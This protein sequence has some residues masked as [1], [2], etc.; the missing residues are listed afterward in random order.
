MNPSELS[1]STPSGSGSK[2]S[3]MND[4]PIGQTVVEE[5][6]QRRT[7]IERTKKI[8]KLKLGTDA[9]NRMEQKDEES[10]DGSTSTAISYDRSSFKSE[11]KNFAPKHFGL[12]PE[13]NSNFQNSN[14]K[15]SNFW[16]L[17]KQS[18]DKNYYFMLYFH[19]KKTKTRLVLPLP[20][21]LGLRIRNGRTMIRK[22]L[23]LNQGRPKNL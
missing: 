7:V 12:Y 13:N 6:G 23:T 22:T 20:M 17:C 10:S 16:I 11:S 14:E 9:T 4:V 8:I 3:A 21:N 19:R 5:N 15:V 2:T 1:N 18:L